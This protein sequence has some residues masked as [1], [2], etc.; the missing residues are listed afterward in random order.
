MTSL[1]CIVNC[2]SF[3]FILLCLFVCLFVFHFFN[4]LDFYTSTF[5]EEL[6]TNLRIPKSDKKCKRFFNKVLVILPFKFDFTGS[7]LARE[8]NSKSVIRTCVGRCI[9]EWLK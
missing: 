8:I 6:V 3:V 1:L 4:V 5:I 2:L 9:L 7:L